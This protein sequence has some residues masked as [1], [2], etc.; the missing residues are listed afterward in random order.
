VVAAVLAAGPGAFAS[1]VTAAR[2]WQIEGEWVDEIHLT[3]SSRRRIRLPGVIAYQPRGPVAVTRIGRIPL[4]T[5]AQTLIDLAPEL[6]DAALEDAVDDARRRN[7]VTAVKMHAMV[8][9]KRGRGR[10][11]L[12]RPQRLLEGRIGGPVSGSGKENDLG[13][14]MREANLPPAV[15]QHEIR[16]AGGALVAR[17]DFAY[18]DA[19]VAVEFDGYKF[20]GSRRQWERGKRRDAKLAALGWLVIPVTDRSMT[21]LPEDVVRDVWRALAVRWGVQS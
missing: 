5:C 20:H 3:A 19:K 9:A 21:R 11:G 2:L 8:R 7:L 17:P 10:R 18:P 12:G 13:R 15:R 1:H 14:L 4:T 6:S 16:D